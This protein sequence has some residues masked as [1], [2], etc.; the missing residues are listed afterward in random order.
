PSLGVVARKDATSEALQG[1]ALALRKKVAHQSSVVVMSF[2]PVKRGVT[3]A[4]AKGEW[5]RAICSN[6][7]EYGGNGEAQGLSSFVGKDKCTLALQP[8]G[9]VAYIRNDLT[10][11]C[12]GG[13]ASAEASLQ[14][15]SDTHCLCGPAALSNPSVAVRRGF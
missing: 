3:L 12:N 6:R 15:G 10:P 7:K 8:Y 9:T 11:S 14:A 2:S 1:D 5:V 13:G 4:L